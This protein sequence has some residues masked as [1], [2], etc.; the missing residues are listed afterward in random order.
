MEAAHADRCQVLRRDQLNSS[1]CVLA[2]GREH[3][4]A[5]FCRPHRFGIISRFSR[6]GHFGYI[7][8]QLAVSVDTEVEIVVG[9]AHLLLQQLQLTVYQGTNCE[10]W[11]CIILWLLANEFVLSVLGSQL[12]PHDLLYL[13]SNGLVLGADGRGLLVALWCHLLGHFLHLD[14]CLSSLWSFLPKLWPISAWRDM[15]LALL[16][17]Q[18]CLTQLFI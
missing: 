3:G 8:P 1:S 2:L 15:P 14:R 10:L 17:S 5:R 18:V 16:W 9:L 13:V 4:L 11:S 12:L 7:I 6:R